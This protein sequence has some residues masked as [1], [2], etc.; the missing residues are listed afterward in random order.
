M[1]FA[2]AREELDDARADSET[3]YFEEQ[4]AAATQYDQRFR[5]CC[6]D[7]IK[8]REHPAHC[9]CVNGTIELWHGLL[10]RLSNADQAALQRSMGLKM[11]QLK[12][13]LQ[14]VFPTKTRTP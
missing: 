9:R 12:V 2:E 10:K 13:C 11:E 4:L 3:V 7:S 1:R 6:Q 8:V 14:P 5:V